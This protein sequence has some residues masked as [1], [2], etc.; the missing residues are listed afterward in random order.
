M[1]SVDVIANVQSIK[2]PGVI[3]PQYA[4]LTDVC[5]GCEAQ[6]SATNPVL[7]VYIAT[8]VSHGYEAQLA[9][10]L[11][12]V[13]YPGLGHGSGHVGTSEPLGPVAR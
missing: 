8:G 6:L 3:G 1:K 11:D 2:P 12:G 13:G 10:T 7:A 4:P 9:G 5:G